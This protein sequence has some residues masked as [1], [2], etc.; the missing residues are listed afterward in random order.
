MLPGASLALETATR[1]PRPPWQDIFLINLEESS[2]PTMSN[3]RLQSLVLDGDG[4]PHSDQLIAWRHHTDF[5]HLG[6]LE[7]QNGVNLEALRALTRIAE[8][9]ELKSLRTLALSVYPYIYQEES[10]LDEAAHLLLQ[11]LNPLENMELRGF[12]ADRT[13]TM[14][15]HRHGATLAKFRFLPVRQDRMQVKPYVISHDSIQEM[16]KRCPN[17]QEIERLIARTQGDEQ[18]VSIYRTLG[19]LPRLHC[20][21]LTLDCSHFPDRST[22]IDEDESKK[23]S[24]VRE[25]LI[26]SAID[27]SLALAMFH[28]I[29]SP[30]LQSLELEVFEGGDSDDS[31]FSDIVRWI[32]RS[33]I[34][35]KT[36]DGKI[37]VREIGR[38]ERLSSWFLES[39]EANLEEYPYGK[40]Y[41]RIWREL[42]PDERTGDWKEDWRSFPLALG[43]HA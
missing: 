12:I 34:C 23:A 33:W 39:L 15:L 4:A 28:A 16:Q 9:G 11:I 14:V 1:T 30:T 10:H 2:G 22:T 19:T 42:W 26:N 40:I 31:N 8:D 37:A 29:S 41:K 3:G 35:I 24:R 20:A 25:K 32:G 36:P 7:I 38:E 13:F 5:S 6:F 43:G 27:S 18:E 21:S 17:L